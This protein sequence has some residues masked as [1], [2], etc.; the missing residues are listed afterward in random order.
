M[1]QH[2]GIDPESLVPLS[3]LYEMIP[4][5]FNTIPD[6]VTRRATLDGLLQAMTADLP[7]NPNVATEDRVI[8]GPAGDLTVRIYQ[9][10]NASGPKPGLLFIHGG[11]MVLG[12][13]ETDHLTAVMLCEAIG[14]VVVSVDYRLA[15]EHPAPAAIDDCFAGLRWM[16]SNASDLGFD[17]ARLG[18]LRGQRRWRTGH[19]DC[20]DV[21]RQRR[22]RPGLPHAGLS[23]DR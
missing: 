14:A 11:D 16:A 2:D 4:G 23:H 12:N 5:G 7:A 10:Q 15:P 22:S 19:R 20:P 13:L 6:I 1:P 18:G 21:A 3:A 17:L 8:P 9:P